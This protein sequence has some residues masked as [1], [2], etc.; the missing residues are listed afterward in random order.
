ME[1]IIKKREIEKLGYTVQEKGNYHAI[2]SP[3]GKTSIEIVELPQTILVSNQKREEDSDIIVVVGVRQEKPVAICG[4]RFPSG[5][6][7]T[8]L[9]W[10]LD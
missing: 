9:I 10:A 7:Y 6:S 3:T 8:A 2:I 1:L 4:R 5:Q